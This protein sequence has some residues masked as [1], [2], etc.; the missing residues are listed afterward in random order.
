MNAYFQTRLYPSNLPIKTYYIENCSFIP[1]WHIDVEMLLV[2]EGSIKVSVNDTSKILNAGEIAVFGS[3]D[4]HYFDR[5]NV[6]SK[7]NMIIFRP[8][9]IGNPTGW[10]ENIQFDTPFLTK[11]I[12]DIMGPD[13]YR[14]LIYTFCSIIDEIT[15]KEPFYEICAKGKLMELSSL[16]LRYLPTGSIDSD[17]RM[18]R[19]PDIN[20]IKHAMEFI[21][22]N[23]TND[24]SLASISDEIHFSTYYFSRLFK[25]F[26]GTNFVTYLNKV[27]IEHAEVLIKTSD[28][29]ITDISFECGFKSV[30]TFN[31]VFKKLKGYTPSSLI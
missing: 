2:L 16:L 22:N 29:S 21:E 20:G 15:A 9:I 26:T 31:R 23:Y 5:T 11:S 17:K 1:H 12:I 24:I 19:L 14:Q 18:K 10:P 6:Q 7:I 27:R 8:D 25:R 30:R 4:I 3:T 28:K 13:T